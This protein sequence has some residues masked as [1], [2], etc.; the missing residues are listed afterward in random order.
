MGRGFRSC[1]TNTLSPNIEKLSNIVLSAVGSS[2]PRAQ[3]VVVR[4]LLVIDF[5]ACSIYVYTG[6]ESEPRLARWCPVLLLYVNTQCVD[7]VNDVRAITAIDT[8]GSKTGASG[9][10]RRRQQQ[11]NETFWAHIICTHTPQA[12]S[13][14]REA[15][16]GERDLQRQQH[17]RSSALPTHSHPLTRF[18]KMSSGY[19]ALSTVSLLCILSLLLRDG[20]D[21]LLRNGKRHT[22]GHKGQAICPP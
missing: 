17:S 13:V 4:G 18:I 8:S 15:G 12:S 9:I 5:S 7:F 10:E 11:Y 21:P 16:E 2:R 20:S 14:H 6:T 22:C 3:V 19:G 1:H